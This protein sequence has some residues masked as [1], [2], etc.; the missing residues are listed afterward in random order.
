MLNAFLNGIVRAPLL[1]PVLAVFLVLWSIK[2]HFSFLPGSS[3]NS[4]RRPQ[5][6]HC[7]IDDSSLP[8]GPHDIDFPPHGPAP[9]RK[10]HQTRQPRAQYRDDDAPFANLTR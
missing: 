6:L 8:F 9:V 5:T 1:L 7:K 3:N 4:F 10:G 2:Q